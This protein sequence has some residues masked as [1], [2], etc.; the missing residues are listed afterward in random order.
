MWL[1]QQNQK[2]FCVDVYNNTVDALNARDTDN[3]YIGRS[4]VFFS[5]NLESN[6]IIQQLYMDA[7]VIVHYFNKSPLFWRLWQIF[8]GKK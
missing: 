8:T 4:F 5:T 3:V 2:K 7:M 6:R 1:V